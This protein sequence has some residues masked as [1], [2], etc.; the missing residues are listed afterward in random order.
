MKHQNRHLLYW[1]L[2]VLLLVIG[3]A[4]VR[5]AS[6][7]I[8]GIG[9][10]LIAAGIA[11]SVIFFYVQE[12]EQVGRLL[13]ALRDFGLQRI[14][15]GRGVRIREEYDIAISKA[16]KTIDVLGFGLRSL[17]EDYGNS[18]PVW[19]ARAPVRVLLIDPEYP[20]VRYCYADQRDSE[21]HNQ[22]GD[23]TRDVKEFVKRTAALA[24]GNAQFRIRLY[25][26][27]PSV[28]LF[29]ID[30]TMFWGPYLVGQQSRN[31][32]TFVLTKGGSLYRRFSEHFDS[33]WNSDDLSREV[34][35]E[36]RR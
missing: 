10:S 11:G 4:L 31:M 24:E 32:P 16:E 22:K 1:V 6:L 5:S 8:V 34:P 36:W 26:C 9:T 28:N 27:L 33:I 3:L 30:N 17:L 12:T 35:S 29:R 18:F 21:E 7:I 20:S 2:H 14:H 13:E 15:S 23:I 25:R 19:A